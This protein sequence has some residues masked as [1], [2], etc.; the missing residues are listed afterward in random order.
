MTLKKIKLSNIAV[1][2]NFN[3][4]LSDGINIIIGENGSGKTIFLKSIYDTCHDKKQDVLDNKYIRKHNDNTDCVPNIF[5]EYQMENGKI[6]SCWL[7]ENGQKLCVNETNDVLYI[8][9]MEMLSHSKGLISLYEKYDLP[10]ENVQIDII[11][12]AQLPETRKPADFEKNFWTLS[13]MLSAEKLCMKMK[14]F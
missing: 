2:V 3:L 14:N 12:N 8:P 13:V 1:F 10:F 11:Q 6:E 4:E 5:I 7:M 9:V